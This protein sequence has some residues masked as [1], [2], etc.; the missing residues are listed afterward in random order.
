MS[1]HRSWRSWLPIA[2]VAFGSALFLLTPAL[3]LDLTGLAGLILGDWVAYPAGVV[4][5][6]LFL[7]MV[8]THRKPF[9]LRID[10]TGVVWRADGAGGAASWPE[11]V[12]IAIERKP[13]DPP[14]RRPSQLTLWLR[15]PVSSGAE[16]D[17]RLDGLIGYRLADIRVLVESAEEIVAGL[18]RYTPTTPPTVAAAAGPH[19]PTWLVE[20]PAASAYPATIPD[21]G[22]AHPVLGG[23]PSTTPPAG[24]DRRTPGDGECAYCGSAPARFIQLVSAVSWGLG[25]SVRPD[26]AWMCRDCAIARYRA[27]TTRMF[28]GA[29]WGP[30]L[31][32]LPIFL[33]SNRIRMRPV[34]TMQP[35]AR[36][37]PEIVAPHD[38]PLDPGPPLRRRAATLFA[39]LMTVVIVVV[40][41]CLGAALTSNDAV[42]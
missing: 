32:A 42:A 21:G 3:D 38:Q 20:A 36:R 8:H 24:Y 28:W 18:R 25:Y 40:L 17:V 1:L 2:L 35:P 26:R 16:P 34:A 37:L 6:L 10:E 23:A 19:S 15:Q 5:L 7:Y 33:V 13:D 27:Q 30:G 12:R 29:W 14:Q 31:I 41:I 4:L 9:L 22:P 11:I 39:I